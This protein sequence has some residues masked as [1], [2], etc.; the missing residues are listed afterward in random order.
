MCSRN[1]TH[2]LHIYV[3]KIENKFLKN[4]I[5]KIKSVDKFLQIRNSFKKL[6]G[7]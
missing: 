4:R 1:H 2:K 5:T 3:H 7:R 6:F